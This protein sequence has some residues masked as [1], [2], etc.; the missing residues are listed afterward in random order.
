[1]STMKWGS[2][3]SALC[4]LWSHMLVTKDKEKKLDNESWLSYQI[5]GDLIFSQHFL[6]VLCHLLSGHSNEK[7]FWG[8]EFVLLP[9]LEMFSVHFLRHRTSR[10]SSVSWPFN[11]VSASLKLP[12]AFMLK[13]LLT[14]FF[15]SLFFKFTSPSLS[16]RATLLPLDRCLL[17]WKF[18]DERGCP[19]GSRDLM[20]QQVEE[21]SCLS[22]PRQWIW[23]LVPDSFCLCF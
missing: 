1:M 5:I 9:K 3:K 4:T 23:Y 21:S 14:P 7:N 2:E 6:A 22:P 19:G 8:G 20:F 13:A 11:Y 15:Q 18:R 12:K 16:H 17:C 10:S